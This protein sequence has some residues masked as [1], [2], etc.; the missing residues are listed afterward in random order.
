M[1]TFLM[2]YV[3]LDIVKATDMRQWLSATFKLPEKRLHKAV[4]SRYP[5]SA[6]KQNIYFPFCCNVPQI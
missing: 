4:G 1:E 6:T 3:L 2:I 5:N